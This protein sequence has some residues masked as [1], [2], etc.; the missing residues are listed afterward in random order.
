M[1]RTYRLPSKQPGTIEPCMQNS[2]GASKCVGNFFTFYEI[3]KNVQNAKINSHNSNAC[4]I[5]FFCK[6]F[7][8][9][10][11]NDKNGFAN[12]DVLLFS[13]ILTSLLIIITYKASIAIFQKV[14]QI[15][16]YRRGCLCR[17]K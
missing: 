14:F 6:M 5:F 11:T 15:Q 12:H 10:A 4:K 3:A 16:H 1:S 7:S 13:H 9:E 17:E 8:Q 2:W